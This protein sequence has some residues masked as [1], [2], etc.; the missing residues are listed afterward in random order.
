MKR[1]SVFG[2]IYTDLVVYLI[3]GSIIVAG[4]YIMSGNLGEAINLKSI[5]LIAAGFGAFISGNFIDIFRK[6]IKHL[7]KD[8]FGDPDFDTLKIEYDDNFE[9]RK[10]VWLNK[11]ISYFKKRKYLF[12]P[13]FNEKVAKKIRREFGEITEASIRCAWRK[14]RLIFSNN[15]ETFFYQYDRWYDL[16]KFRAN[17]IFSFFFVS[18]LFLVKEWFSLYYLILCFLLVLLYCFYLFYV[19]EDDYRTERYIWMCYL[20]PD[21]K[22]ENS[23]TGKYIRPSRRQNAFS[24]PP[25]ARSK[26]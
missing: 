16:I 21:A 20:E 18:L 14:G 11:R 2:I 13:K 10:I 3:P 22:G 12:P 19:F 1:N 7:Y 8:V 17:C 24:K 6:F 5:H 26:K 25:S 23:K 9:N 15:Y 4:L